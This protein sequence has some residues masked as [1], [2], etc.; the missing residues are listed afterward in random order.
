M[1]IKMILA[2]GA[3][4]FIWGSTY[5]A[6][7][8]AIETIP[9]F[10]MMGCR[11]LLAGSILYVWARLRGEKCPHLTQWLIAA[12]VGMLLFFAGHGSLAWSGQVV[13]S[14]VAALSVATAPLWM[15]LLQ[16]FQNPHSTMNV[17][18]A[19]GI[20]AGLGGVYLMVKPS[21]LLSGSPVNPVGAVVLL[22]GTLSW[23]AGS[24]YSKSANLPKSSMLASG[25][26]LLCGGGGLL[27]LSL[28]SR[29]RMDLT[30]VS[31]RSLASLL[32]L[33]A[34]GSI[35]AFSAYFWLLRKTSP[36]RVSTYAYVNPVIAIF[37]GWF[38]G[39]ESLSPRIIT[40]MLLMVIGVAA[41]VT[42]NS[43]YFSSAEKSDSTKETR[44]RAFLKGESA[45]H[46]E[47]I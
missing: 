27:L 37:L 12:S 25:M 21:E 8:F 47:A 43:T 3:I 22:F 16:A 20:V 33:A 24:V 26:S 45:Q 31:F 38:A 46:K 44:K 30:S 1:K 7:R 18:V 39:G 34:F 42:Q 28:L 2:F 15:I 14:G 11:M 17:R 35:I 6:I 32:Y 23:S 13:P 4:Y 5:L 9:P 36:V 40:A 19:I 41:I 29:E 10:L